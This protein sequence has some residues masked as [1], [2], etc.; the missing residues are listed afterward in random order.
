MRSRPPAMANSL[1]ERFGVDDGLIGDL[2][3]EGQYH[4][5]A[6]FWRQTIVALAKTAT[7][8]VRARKVLALRALVVGWIMQRL[9]VDQARWL[10][11]RQMGSWVWK[12]A[13]WFDAHMGFPIDLPSILVMTI[14]GP[15]L[16]GWVVGRLH[17]RQAMPMVLTYMAAFNLFELAGV[18]NSI[19]SGNGLRNHQ[20]QAFMFFFIFVVGPACMTLGGLWSVPTGS[21]RKSAA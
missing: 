8:D 20:L 14:V 18:V 15:A 12:S 10:V 2:A 4:S 1:L 21:V 7:G 3:E 17:R 6:W 16:I 9:V 13:V 19:A 11:S 5:R